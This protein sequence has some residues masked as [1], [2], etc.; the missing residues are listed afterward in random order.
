MIPDGIKTEKM[1][2]AVTV[3]FVDLHLTLG[4]EAMTEIGIKGEKIKH[5]MY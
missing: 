5:F 4:I 2:K 1:D 3:K